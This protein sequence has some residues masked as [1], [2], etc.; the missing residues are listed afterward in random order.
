MKN[1]NNKDQSFYDSLF[2]KIKNKPIVSINFSGNGINDKNIN[3]ICESLKKHKIYLKEVDFS[4]NEITNIG[5]EKLLKQLL[6]KR[7]ITKIDISENCIGNN[8]IKEEYD[9]FE[10]DYK[11]LTSLE[12]LQNKNSK[13]A[14]KGIVKLIK[15]HAY[16]KINMDNNNY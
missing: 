9:P 12:I 3:E 16:V 10:N 5:A 8:E 4:I 14:F 2:K 7:G 6:E 11:K 15:E 1:T 13:E